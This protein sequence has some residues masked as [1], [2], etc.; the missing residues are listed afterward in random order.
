MIAVLTVLFAPTSQD[1]VFKKLAPKKAIAAALGV[2][3]GALA[4]MIGGGASVEFI[5]FQ[6]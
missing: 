3:A 1:V 6:F 2:G 5:Y 4:I